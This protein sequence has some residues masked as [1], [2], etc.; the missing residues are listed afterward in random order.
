LVG[1]SCFSDPEFLAIREGH[2]KELD[3]INQLEDTRMSI[4]AFDREKMVK[5]LVDRF[6]GWKMPD[7]VCSDTC[8]SMRPYP[9]PRYGTNLLNADEARQMIEYVLGFKANPGGGHG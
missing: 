9:H 4:D 2:S 6:L 3:R 5:A 7:S 1:C 8:V